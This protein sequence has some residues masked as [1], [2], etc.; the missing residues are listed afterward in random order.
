MQDAETTLNTK[1]IFYRIPLNPTLYRDELVS[2]EAGANCDLF[3]RGGFHPKLS[4]IFGNI[5]G[6]IFFGKEDVLTSV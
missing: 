5:K 4:L 1:A 6:E 2:H 3:Q